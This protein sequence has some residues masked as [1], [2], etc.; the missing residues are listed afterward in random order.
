[1]RSFAVRS[2]LFSVLLVG[3]LAANPNDSQK[4]QQAD[5]MFARAA[6]TNLRTAVSPFHLRIEVHAAHLGPKPSDGTYDEMWRSPD[7]WRRQISF[8][9]FVQQEVGDGQGRWLARNLD[10]RPRAIYLLSHA[11]ETEMSVSLFP[12]EQV[13][14]ISDRKKDAVDLRCVESKVGKWERILCFDPRGGL[15]SVDEHVGYDP[16]KL[17]FR[18]MDF[19]KLGE[20]LYARHIQVYENGDQALDMKVAELSLLPNAA[21]A[22]FDH[23]PTDRLMAIC[24]RWEGTAPVRRVTPQYPSEALSTHQQGTVTLYAALAA[25]GSVERLK[26]LEGAGQGLNNASMEAV[27]LW[28]YAPLTCGTEKPLPSEIE[29]R[30]NFSLAAF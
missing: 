17:Q 16:R 29:V 24:D 2:V 19:Q 26:L 4:K 12:E 5:D 11:L 28:M 9:G 18:Y 14:K 30:V 8:P 20:K 13:Q 15:A 6:V 3:A 25:D 10:F 1:M 21:P 7:A 23:A 22:H 27:K